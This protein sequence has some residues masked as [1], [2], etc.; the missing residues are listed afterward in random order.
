[1][2]DDVLDAEIDVQGVMLHISEMKWPC[3]KS[4]MKHMWMRLAKEWREDISFSDHSLEP[5]HI[6]NVL[7]SARRP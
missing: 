6:L 1:M 2:K 4:I 7:T 3:N 5:H